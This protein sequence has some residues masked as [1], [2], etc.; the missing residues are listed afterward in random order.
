MSDKNPIPLWDRFAVKK[1]E[2]AEMLGMS[3][4][5]F[6]RKVRQGLAPAPSRLPG[7]R[8]MWS[9]DALRQHKENPPPL[10]ERMPRSVPHGPGRHHL[11]RHFDSDGRLLYVGVSLS[12]LARLAQHKAESEWFWRIAKVEITAYAS[13]ETVL[14]A[15]R[16]AIRQEKPLHN[17]IHSLLEAA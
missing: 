7:C 10:K 16:I 3:V 13:R 2:A 12:T 5:S 6:D 15:E 4:S 9:V 1:A 17:I 11:Y 14:E 8:P